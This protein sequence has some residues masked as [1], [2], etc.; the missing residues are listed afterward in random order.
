MRPSKDTYYMEMAKVA[1]TRGT[2][3]RRKVGCILV[4]KFGH[5]IATGRNGVAT[6][7]AHCNHHD[8]FDPIG[9]PHACEGATAKSGT[10]LDA[11]QAIHAE[12]NALLQC[13]DVQEID[14]AYVTTKPCVSCM[15]L[16]MN[17]SCKRIV[18]LEDYPH[19]ATYI[20]AIKA[21]I[22]LEKY[23]ADSVS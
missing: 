17:T 15:K 13:K 8:P 21:G 3:L 19:S 16:F 2:C 4:N 9:F 7:V 1:S 10:N 18:Y 20:L 5:I 22:K 6:G 23:D 11:C 12:Q 14:V